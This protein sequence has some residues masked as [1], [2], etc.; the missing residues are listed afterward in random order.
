MIGQTSNQP[1]RESKQRSSPQKKIQ[2]QEWYK[3]H[4]CTHYKRRF[5]GSHHQ[6]SSQSCLINIVSDSTLILTTPL[7]FA[8]VSGKLCSWSD[9][10]P[11]P[12]CF[13][14]VVLESFDSHIFSSPQE[15]WKP[16][17]FI[18]VT[19]VGT[20]ACS[21]PNQSLVTTTTIQ[22]FSLL[23]CCF[24]RHWFAKCHCRCS[25]LSSVPDK[26]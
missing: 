23:M 4:S 5:Q 11:Y 3:C 15:C 25:I 10:T 24:S 14:K 21:G 13:E 1:P 26:R 16:S 22:L 8:F 19:R 6:K 18:P 9:K 17:S 20:S 7:L 2:D 12:W